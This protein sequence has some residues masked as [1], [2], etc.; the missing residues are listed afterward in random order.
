MNAQN[1]APALTGEQLS[2]VV[3]RIFQG[4]QPLTEAEA[5]G[6]LST[7]DTET[8]ALVSQASR[9]RTQHFSN[10]VKVN[11]LVSLK[12]G[13]CPENCTYCSQRLGS[14]ADILKYTWLKPEEAVHQASLGIQGGA[15]RVCMV[16]SG[17]GPTHRD[18]TRV[19]KMVEELKQQHP[20][21]EVCACLGKL[22]DG[23]AQKLRE[24]GVDAY[25]HNLNTSESMYPEICTSH[26]YQDRVDTV[27]QASGAGLSSCSG[28]IVGMGETDA[29][30]V[31]AVFALREL[32]A[33]SI[34]VNFL[35]PFDGTPLEGHWELT[36]LMCLR[37]LAMVRMACPDKELRIAGGRE[38]H[39]RTLQP[40]ALQVANSIFLGDYLT[41][42]GQAAEDDLAMIHDA[43]FTVLGAQQH[44]AA[45][46]PTA[47]HPEGP[48]A[49]G[50]T[51]PA[52]SASPHAP[53]QQEPSEAA[54][55]APAGGCCGS[56]GGTGCGSGAFDWSSPQSTEASQPQNHRIDDQVLA[57]PMAAPSSLGPAPGTRGADSRNP[58]IRRRGAGT[59]EPANA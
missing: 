20:Q 17:T 1:T 55:A 45:Q 47:Q 5:L 39:L 56:A 31:E 28:L 51:S 29:Q 40:V 33:D 59:E 44:P 54:S 2:A 21:V 4:G 34:P 52:A 10:T 36:P 43:G 7:P 3:D 18:I 23:Q 16:A 9:L 15:T 53:A 41:S 27:E 12:T 48:A 50:T 30:R 14:K 11:Y 22:K 13:L 6:V 24:A 37:I 8:F 19:S 26:T 57:S 38:M 25:N 32:D 58:A 35:M 49:A 46:T 42:E